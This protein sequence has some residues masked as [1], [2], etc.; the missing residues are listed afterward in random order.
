MDFSKNFV[1]ET[2]GSIIT[3]FFGGSQCLLA[4]LSG[5]SRICV[6]ILPK[7][8][9]IKFKVYKTCQGAGSEAR[10]QNKILIN[11]WLNELKIALEPIFQIC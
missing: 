4:I 2:I 10:I 1:N 7:D 5:Y 6:H 3:E 9:K 8:V 11:I